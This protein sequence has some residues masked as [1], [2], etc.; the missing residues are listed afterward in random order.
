MRLGDPPPQDG[1]VRGGHIP[2][3]D[4]AGLGKSSETPTKPDL[5]TYLS[6]PLVRLT[7]RELGGR[8]PPVPVSA[9]VLKPTTNIF[10]HNPPTI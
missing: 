10:L 4:D 5:A 9:V 2:P 1:G 7:Q 3:V 8:P 6:Q